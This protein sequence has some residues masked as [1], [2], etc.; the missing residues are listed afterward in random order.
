MCVLPALTKKITYTPNDYPFVYYSEILKDLCYVD[1]KDKQ[2]PMKDGCGKSYTTAEFDSVMPLLNFR[3]RMVDGTLPDSI[4]GKELTPP[5]I[6][7][8]SVIYK[9]SPSKINT[10]NIGLYIMFESMPKRVGLELPDDVFRMKQSIEFIDNQ[11]NTVNIEKSNL[12]ESELNKKG[13]SFPVQWVSGNMNPRKKYD[14][15]YFV[16]D[17]KSQ[18]YHLKMVNNRPYV[19]N[20][21]IGDKI[22]IA[23]FSM[24]EAGDKRFYGFLFSKQGEIYIVGY[25]EGDYNFQK[26]DIDPIDINNDEILMMGNLL[27]W[28]ITITKPDGE[29]IYALDNESLQCVQSIEIPRTPGRWDKVSQWIYPIYIT[30]SHPNN[31]YIYPQVNFTGYHGFIFNAILGLL[32]AVLVPNP[33]KKRIL[34][35]VYIAIT[36]IAGLI[37]LL[38]LPKFSTKNIKSK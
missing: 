29:K 28:T 11:S 30:T 37:A 10:P 3:Q 16:L 26:L 2:N 7:S 23:N 22:D 38:L 25:D 31:D 32:F 1:Y 9:Y 6:M 13:F 27:Y 19:S 36:G 14:E 21:G 34:L 24:Y 15:G 5:I 35:F 17:D 12:F 20:T 18:L 4:D 33:F 8:K